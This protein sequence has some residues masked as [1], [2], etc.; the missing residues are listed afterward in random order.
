M[1]DYNLVRLETLN[2][3]GQIGK[4]DLILVS[5]K[6]SDGSFSSV[7]MSGNQAFEVS[8]IR[9]SDDTRNTFFRLRTANDC[10]PIVIDPDS[11]KT[12]AD[13][14]KLIA[15]LLDVYG[16][17]ICALEADGGGGGGTQ[18]PP[19]A[20][21]PP[22]EQGPEGPRGPSGPRGVPGPKGDHGLSAYEIWV[23]EDP[24]NHTGG[25][26]AF[27]EDIKGEDGEHGDHGLSAY[28]EWVQLDPSN[29][30]MSEAE[31]IASLKG[32]PG[33][34]GNDG[35]PGTPGT[36]GT[37]G[38]EGPRGPA[39]PDGK[40]AYQVWLDIPNTGTEQEFLDSLKGDE[41]PEGPIGPDGPDG[42]EGPRGK[43]AY[44][45]WLQTNPDPV[46]SEPDWVESLNGTDGADGA[47]GASAYEVY[48]QDFLN[49][50]GD[51]SDVLPETE[52][53]ASL[54]GDD[55]KSAY[56]IAYDQD[57]TI[58][59]ETEWLESLKGDPGND[60]A[61]GAPGA[62][63]FPD[64][65]GDDSLVYGRV[66]SGTSSWSRVVSLGGD[67]MNGRLV[68]PSITVGPDGG[69]AVIDFTHGSGSHT[70]EATATG[71][72]YDGKALLDSDYQTSNDLA[73]TQ[74]EAKVDKNTQDLGDFN[75]DLVSLEIKVSKNE[76][77]I[78]TN[79][80]AISDNEEAISNLSSTVESHDDRIT[81]NTEAITLINSSITDIQTDIDDNKEA[82]V[83][84]NG[85]IA[86]LNADLGPIREDIIT[87]NN[88]ISENIIDIAQL[89]ADVVRIDSEIVDLHEADANN[90]TA[91]SELVVR[92][93]TNEGDISDLQD[94]TS[95]NSEDIATK[96]NIAGDTMTGWLKW[97]TDLG[98]ELWSDDSS[99]KHAHIRR[100]SWGSEIRAHNG[101]AFKIYASDE[102]NTIKTIFS[103]ETKNGVGTANLY[104]LENPSDDNHAANR[105]TVRQSVEDNMPIGAIIFWG[106]TR[107]KIPTGWK[108]CN[109][110]AGGNDYKTATGRDN[111]PDLKNRMPAGEGGVFGSGLNQLKD[112]KIKSHT[113][114]VSRQEPGST[115]GNPNAPKDTSNS[116]F[117]YWRGNV[118]ENG[119]AGPSVS[120]TSS[121]TGDSITA[122]PVY[123]GVYIAKT[124]YTY[125]I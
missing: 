81:G 68:L 104:N 64:E 27:L 116:R 53:L 103:C 10:F 50:G 44:A 120:K 62:D 29:N 73:L 20:Q 91:I 48:V 101:K 105:R 45:S 25:E 42:P 32:D 55:G 37:Q 23:L 74:L 121:S 18:G 5:K 106:G 119:D 52:W 33:P 22:G 108:E 26:T 113:H 79:T 114:T 36:P 40:S 63:G 111:L 19:G 51:I 118:N 46:L 77:N 47:P 43:S 61:P 99:E 59:T 90:A 70:L 71:L 28:E 88:L 110:Q 58:G 96:V 112:S 92:V 86:Q 83:E 82:I 15:M 89:K 39:G 14:D 123:L 49:T 76:T 115:N 85:N 94:A 7:N 122:P 6:N 21:G 30:T 78:G 57:N 4:D 97:K 41:G 8:N 2:S 13:A 17:K 80:G 75:T 84:I 9:L 31:W 93:T 124:S 109:G 3:I 102:N 34:A 98:I 1:T 117:R 12:Q 24:L 35:A 69:K 11:L 16:Q 67:T 87:N 95:K 56:E 60:G 107:D 54:V 65:P 125:T 38:S 66:T 72:L 100:T